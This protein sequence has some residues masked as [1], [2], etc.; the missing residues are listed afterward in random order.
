VD[1]LVEARQVVDRDFDGARQ[2]VGEGLDPHTAELVGE[3]PVLA[4]DEHGRAGGDDRHV[5]G[6]LLRHAD[7][8]EVHVQGTACHG[9]RLDALD[10]GRRRLLA[11]DKEVKQDGRRRVLAQ[12]LELVRVDADVRRWD[13]MA[14]DNARKSPGAPQAGNPLARLL[15]ALGG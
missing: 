11:V 4:L 9:V 15:T 3:R 1:G 2:V 5:D 14:E 10:D 13:A 6:Q 7:R 8:E 12:Q